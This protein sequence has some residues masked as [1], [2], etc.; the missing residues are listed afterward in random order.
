MLGS[1]TVIW[2]SGVRY[3]QGYQ[4][5]S[6][7][8]NQWTALQPLPVHIRIMRLAT[9]KHIGRLLERYHKQKCGY[10]TGVGATAEI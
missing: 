6:H 4:H 1:R 9:Q 3:Q 5:R 10:C 8:L 7:F 2:T